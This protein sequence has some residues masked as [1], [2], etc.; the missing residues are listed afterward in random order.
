MDLT[1]VI[2]PQPAVP[3]L[4]PPRQTQQQQR[5]YQIDLHL[6]HQQFQHQQQFDQMYLD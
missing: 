1:P 6:I 5:L 2:R 3:P 4:P